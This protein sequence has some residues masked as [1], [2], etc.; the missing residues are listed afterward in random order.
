MGINL[1]ASAY[2]NA[3]WNMQLQDGSED[4][5]GHILPQIVRA[6]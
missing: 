3:D 6:A 5:V 1:K 4:G 2:N